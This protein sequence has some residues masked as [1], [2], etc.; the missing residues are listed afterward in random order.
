MAHSALAAILVVV[1]VVISPGV[2]LEM[3]V[4]EVKPHFGCTLES[5][6]E[7][8]R[9]LVSSL[10]N[11]SFG[12]IALLQAEFSIP[13][14]QGFSAFGASCVSQNADAAVVLYNHSAFELLQ[15]IGPTQ[16]HNY[17]AMPYLY[18]GN[19]PI[20]G[21]SCVGDVR[22]DGERAYTGAVLRDRRTGE[23]LCV[24][25]ATFPH[26]LNPVGQEFLTQISGA[27]R[28]RPILFVV[29]T[30]TDG[31]PMDAIGEDLGA[32][33]G[34]CSDPGAVGDNTCCHDIKK[35]SPVARFKF[36]RTAV[37]NGGIVDNW[38]VG[39]SWVCGADE[40]HHY[41]TARVRT[42]P[43]MSHAMQIP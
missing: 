41:T 42:T 15:P 28:G 30:N 43:K 6:R 2:A 25:A 8:V 16:T 5:G 14:P 37:C 32:G 24:I 20:N 36:D 9:G 33:W 10:V 38:A 18:D 29:D 7:R 22:T 3:N 40:E 23:A 12:V 13:Q 31:L 26:F 11:Q 21:S 4:A 19:P 34:N 27:C 1:S 17:R 39:K 35:G